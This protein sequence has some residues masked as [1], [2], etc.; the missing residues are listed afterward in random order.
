VRLGGPVFTRCGGPDEW[1]AALKGLGYRAAYC[2]VDRETDVT[3][4]QA[5][6]EAATSA[7]ILIAEV[8]A[9]SNAQHGTRN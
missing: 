4:A 7:D 3:T 9:W 6:V 1:V 5:Y 2:P 8:G